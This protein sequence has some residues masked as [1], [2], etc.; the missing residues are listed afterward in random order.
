MPARCE[1]CAAVCHVWVRCARALALAACDLV[2]VALL[3]ASCM[4]LCSL[5]MRGTPPVPFPVVY[6]PSVTQFPVLLVLSCVCLSPSST[7]AVKNSDSAPAPS[8]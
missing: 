7:M 5:A 3:P 8:Q 6:G 4:R 2:S 1:L